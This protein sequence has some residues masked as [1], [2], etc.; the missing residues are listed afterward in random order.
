LAEKEIAESAF[1]ERVQRLVAIQS[2]GEYG[3]LWAPLP[4]KKQIRRN[5]MRAVSLQ[6]II[7]TEGVPEWQ[8]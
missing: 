2:S 6:T 4:D 7:K 8:M 5:R 3:D 1:Q